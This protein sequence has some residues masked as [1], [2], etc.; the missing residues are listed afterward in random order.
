M[1]ARNFMIQVKGRTPKEAFHTAVEDNRYEFGHGGYTGTI[2]EKDTF[3]MIP[4]PEGQDPV[5]F[6]EGLIDSEDKRVSDKWGPAGC[7]KVSEGT[8]LFFGVASL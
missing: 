5:R 1:G 6:A 8:F 2:A 7:I 4:L 3:T